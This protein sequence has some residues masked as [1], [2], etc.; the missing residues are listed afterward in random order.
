M[1]IFFSMKT[2]QHHRALLLHK[3]FKEWDTTQSLLDRAK[4]V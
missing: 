1:K 4:S 2:L 3:L